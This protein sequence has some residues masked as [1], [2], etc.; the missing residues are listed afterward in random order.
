MCHA[1]PINY[2]VQDMRNVAATWVSGRD[3]SLSSM[4][5]KASSMFQR[6]LICD[7]LSG[8][9]QLQDVVQFC[10]IWTVRFRLFR[11]T[12]HSPSRFC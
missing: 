4:L 9:G 11:G 5:R 2:L 3:L 1:E 10:C 6:C 12:V 8:C 7:M